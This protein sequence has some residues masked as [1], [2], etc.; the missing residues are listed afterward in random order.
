[1]KALNSDY[2]ELWV[3][4]WSKTYPLSHEAPLDK[5]RGLPHF[6]IE[7]MAAL[8]D[9]KYPPPLA[10]RRLFRR[11]K[12]RGLLEGNSEQAVIDATAAAF[13][14]TDDGRALTLVTRLSGVGMAIGSTALMAHDPERFTVY[15]NQASKSLLALGYLTQRESWVPYLRGC[16]AVAMDTGHD[17]RAVDRA[18]FM[19]KGRLTLPE[20]D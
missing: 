15:D 10:G 5:L 3:N 12:I 19:A 9:W 11:D 6:T 17:L 13:A 2:L 14:Q 1:M 8:V 7:H 4:S 20:L 18:L 16:R